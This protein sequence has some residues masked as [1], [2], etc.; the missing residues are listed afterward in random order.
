LNQKGLYTIHHFKIVNKVYNDCKQLIPER[1]VWMNKTMKCYV[2]NGKM[3]TGVEL[4]IHK[5]KTIPQE[6]MKCSHCGNAIVSSDEYERV[7]KELHPS[8]LERIR[9][10]FKGNTEF[11][12]FKGKVL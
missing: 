4:I 3:E 10:L 2:C 6:I 7:R 12:E 11:I 5:G 9:C 1:G 8:I